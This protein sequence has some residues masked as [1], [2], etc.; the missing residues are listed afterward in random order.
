MLFSSLML[1]QSLILCVIV[2]IY[3][4]SLALCSVKKFQSSPL[5]FPKIEKMSIADA[6]CWVRNLMIRLWSRVD[7]FVWHCSILAQCHAQGTR[8]SLDTF[9]L[10]WHHAEAWELHKNIIMLHSWNPMNSNQLVIHTNFLA[11]LVGLWLANF[12]H[13]MIS[14]VRIHSI[15]RTSCNWVWAGFSSPRLR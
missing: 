10:G 13:I 7:L 8:R 11:S 6:S 12:K 15:F 2:T 9:C 5:E 14:K 3:C 4:K 1:D